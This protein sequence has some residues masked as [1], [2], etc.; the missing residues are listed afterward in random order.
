LTFQI[1]P[2]SLIDFSSSLTYIDAF[3]KNFVVNGIDYS[4]NRIPGIGRVHEVAEL[5]LHGAKGLYLSFLSE[6]YGRMYVNDAN[7]ESAKPYTTVDIGVGHEG[8]S[9]GKKQLMKVMLSGGISN[10]FDKHYITAV[11][12]NA[13]ANRY[14]EPG[15]VRTFFVNA[16]FDFGIR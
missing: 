13:A 15:P 1:N 4:G 7:S 12:V 3:Y 9:L 6:T 11:T 2:V 14:Y 8:F 5:K 16:R 10:L